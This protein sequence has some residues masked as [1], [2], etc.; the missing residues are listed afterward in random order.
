MTTD[1]RVAVTSVRVDARN[2][3]LH[4]GPEERI[5]AVMQ[6]PVDLPAD[7]SSTGAPCFAVGHGL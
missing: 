5:L 2:L 7:A 3:S 1:G 6:Q 4:V